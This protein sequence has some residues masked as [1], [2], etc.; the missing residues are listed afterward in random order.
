[1]Y[2]KDD[3]VTV[4]IT[5]M[6]TDGEG[7][8]KIDSF[9]FFIKDA[10]VGDTVLAK[11]MKVKKN[12]AFARLM[13]I[14][15]ASPARI[16]PPCPV[17][18]PCGGCQLQAM[19]YK[20]QLSFKENKVFNNL[21]RIGGINPERLKEIFEPIISMDEPFRYRNKAQYPVSK[22]RDGKIIA[23]FYAGRTHNVIACEDCLIGSK[24]HSLIV[25]AVISWMEDNHIEP[26]M[27]ETG[28]VRHILIREGFATGEIMVVL[29]VNCDISAI[30]YSEKAGCSREQKNSKG[31]QLLSEVNCW[32]SLVNALTK[33]DF[34]AID[35]KSRIV[36][37]QLNENR[38]ATNVI[39]GKKCRVLFGKPEIEDVLCGLN[40][41]ISPLSFYQVN[42]IQTQK[43]YATA[44]EF[45]DLKGDEEVWDICCGIGTITLSV[46]AARKDKSSLGKVH[47]IEIVPE[48]IENAKENAVRNNLENVE[49]IC[50]PAEKYMP[51]NRDRIRADVI[52][53]DPPRK[54]MDERALEVMVSMQ[55][56]RIVY[57]S[58]DS[59]TLSRDV[60]YLTEN[61]Y[62]LKRVRTCDMFPHSSHVETVVLITRKEK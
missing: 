23:G 14:T 27:E 46:A 8:G 10:I 59:A 9:P 52:I 26:Y 62:V 40:F 54:G 35:N 16:E 38:E 20:E 15:E 18:R 60:K 17:A 34:S 21:T 57:V 3:I 43:L 39:L 37:I 13:E 56:K 42:P 50:A 45:A 47:G 28:L 48:A 36:S 53:T 11:V 6:G 30:N 61:G 32:D 25:K 44:I 12:Y 4:K 51:E 31:N 5:D 49:F 1:M 41:K 2:K 19:N 58:C 33:L 55:P 24:T 7:I 29:V 22:N